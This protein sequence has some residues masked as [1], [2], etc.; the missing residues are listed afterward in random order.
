[1]N[2]TSITKTS[3]SIYSMARIGEFHCKTLF[4]V[5]VYSGEGPIPHFHIV[6][7]QNGNETCI[8]IDC[9]KYFTHGDKVYEFNSREK[10]TLIEFLN[11]V[12][13]YEED[14]G[15][16]YYDLIWEEWNRNNREH[17]IPKP[18]SMPDYSKL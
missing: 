4:S 8:R 16:T 7:T 13:P 18:E 10:K 3:H 5:R 6:D 9:T 1:M 17:R 14:Y 2:R 12:S 11:T 15:K